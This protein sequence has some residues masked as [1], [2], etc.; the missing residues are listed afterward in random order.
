M[1]TKRIAEDLLAALDEGKTISSIVA[2]NPGFDWDEGYDVSAEILRLRRAR[3]ERT[4]G[5]K[6]G[7]TNR[8]IWA[9]YGATAPIWAYVYDTTLILA[10]GDRATV[11][12]RGSVQPRLEP[13]I[14]FKLKSALPA[15]IEDRRAVL[16]AIEWYA[17]SFEIVDC[18]LADWKFHSAESAADFAL[19]WRLVV[20][21]P[22]AIREAD[23]GKLVDALHDVEVTLRKNGD[24]AERGVGANALGHPASALAHLAAV[25]ARQ[26]QFEPLAAGEIITT[27]TLTA[28]MPIEP[29]EVWSSEY[30]GLPVSG[31]TLTFTR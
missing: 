29:G 4:P 9:E 12:L 13:E 17:P 3:G 28:A 15:G 22:C 20:G 31:L 18:H 21:T 2:R 7:F 1:D 24:V 16:D 19:H 6:I 23:K 11:S 10:A 27:G 26:P 14:A 30:D 5:R 8:N 25:L